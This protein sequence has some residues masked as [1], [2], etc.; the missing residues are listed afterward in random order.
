MVYKLWGEQE[1]RRRPVQHAGVIFIENWIAKQGNR[2]A[3]HS[4]ATCN[5]KMIVH[6]SHP[7]APCS[8]SISKGAMRAM[9]RAAKQ[10]GVNGGE[11]LVTHVI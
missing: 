2:I 10:R 1:Y 8:N 3:K 4:E 7:D 11:L 9:N 5:T 6:Q